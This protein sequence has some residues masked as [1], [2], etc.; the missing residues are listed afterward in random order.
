MKP[1][2]PLANPFYVALLAVAAIFAVTCSAYALWLSGM[3][4][5]GGWEGHPLVQ[6]LRHHGERWLLI[7]LLVLAVLTAASLSTDHWWRTR[8]QQA[9]PDSSVSPSRQRGDQ[10]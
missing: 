5:R 9:D 3:F 6:F 10:T 8:S 4:D 7:E 2:S 1:R